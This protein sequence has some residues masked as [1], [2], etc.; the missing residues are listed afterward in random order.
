MQMD[1]RD[2]A[3]IVDRYCAADGVG[4]LETPVQSGIEQKDALAVG[5][6]DRRDLGLAR[7]LRDAMQI[8]AELAPAPQ[9]RKRLHLVRSH[10]ARFDLTFAARIPKP[11]TLRRLIHL[12]ADQ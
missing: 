1:G 9:I 12:R 8:R 2:I 6:L 10:T 11:G 5:E 7:D 3:G 4:D